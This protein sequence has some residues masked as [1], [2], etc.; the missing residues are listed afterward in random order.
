M[1]ITKDEY[2]EYKKLKEWAEKQKVYQSVNSVVALEDDIDLPIRRSV[3]MVALL[4]CTP[5]FSCCGFDYEGQPFHKS[6]QYR[7]PYIKMATDIMCTKLYTNLGITLSKYGWHFRVN[8]P[9]TILE[10]VLPMNPHWNEDNC[11]HMSEECVIGIGNLEAILFTLKDEFAKEATIYDTN[12]VR[13][14][15]LRFWQYPP[16]QSWTVYKKNLASY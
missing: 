11:I 9:E 6:H 14:N 1:K 3:A 16:K 4:R 10:L 12:F 15:V 2:E 5:I 8:G 7:E 13:R